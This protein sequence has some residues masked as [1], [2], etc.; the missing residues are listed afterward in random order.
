VQSAGFARRSGAT[1]T[2][3]AL[4]VFVLQRLFRVGTLPALWEV[5]SIYLIFGAT[6]N[7][8]FSSYRPYRITFDDHGRRAG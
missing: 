8:Y 2:G 1:A 7:E 3:A 4:Q 5:K 6:Q